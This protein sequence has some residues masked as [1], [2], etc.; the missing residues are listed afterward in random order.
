MVEK[1]E[2]FISFQLL[3]S[4]HNF[5]TFTLI[6]YASNAEPTSENLAYFVSFLKKNKIGKNY[7]LFFPFI[8]EIAFSIA[9]M[10]RNLYFCILGYQHAYQGGKMGLTYLQAVVS[11]CFNSLASHRFRVWR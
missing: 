7:S 11:V 9:F 3:N 5:P 2:I 8:Y 1:G 10:E 6:T 4:C